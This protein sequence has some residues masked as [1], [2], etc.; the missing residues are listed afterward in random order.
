MFRVDE[1]KVGDV[2]DHAT[3]DLFGDIL[4]EAAIPSLHVIHRDSLA[5]GNECRNGAVGITEHK[6]RVGAVLLNEQLNTGQ[7]ATE[8]FTERTCV[9]RQDNVRCSQLQVLEEHCV[10]IGRAHV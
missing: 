2:I 1:V 6:Q 7:G 9:T 3:V 8:K 4:I 10:Q 5:A